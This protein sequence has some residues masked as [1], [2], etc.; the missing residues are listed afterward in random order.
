M[1]F[2]L[3]HKSGAFRLGRT[4][5]QETTMSADPVID[6]IAAVVIF[7]TGFSAGYFV[8]A[9]VSAR[10]RRHRQQREWSF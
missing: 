2:G 8:R 9:Q 4:P 1:N 6:V 10:R 5:G 3:M 7:F